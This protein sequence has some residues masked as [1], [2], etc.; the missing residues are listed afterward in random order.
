[1]G[2]NEMTDL[3]PIRRDLLEQIAAEAP[4]TN[5]IE[6]SWKFAREHDHAIEEL[7]AALAAPVQGEAVAFTTAGMLDRVR[8]NCS[9]MPIKVKR[10]GNE[11]YQIPLYTTPPQPAEVGELVEA[12]RQ[13]IQMNRQHAADQYGDADKAECWSCVVV[14]RNALAKLDANK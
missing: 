2:S 10:S 3:I 9:A 14:L 1:M 4:A 7:R 13:V 5:C 12:A 8:A 11:R 6:E